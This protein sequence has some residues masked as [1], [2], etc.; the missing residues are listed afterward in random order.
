MHNYMGSISRTK[1]HACSAEYLSHNYAN[2]KTYYVHLI[3]MMIFCAGVRFEDLYGHCM[4]YI[5]I[6]M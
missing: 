3:P 6:K 1:T 5:E 2:D 4:Q